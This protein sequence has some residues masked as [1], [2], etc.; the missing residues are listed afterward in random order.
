M[1]RG[2]ELIGEGLRVGR[3]NAAAL[4]KTVQAE[5]DEATPSAPVHLAT[6][7]Y[8]DGVTVELRAL[9]VDNGWETTGGDGNDGGY[10][11]NVT[12]R[13]AG[14]AA[15]VSVEL[16]A[17]VDWL[18]GL[19]SGSGSALVASGGKPVVCG[20]AGGWEVA[21]AAA[22]GRASAGGFRSSF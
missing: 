6:R 8:M 20:S 17:A 22:E 7:E 19:T 16:A 14:G 18:A 2:T 11:L 3:V 4:L 15:A 10:V 13:N 9:Q 21:P 5:Y 12:V 1:G